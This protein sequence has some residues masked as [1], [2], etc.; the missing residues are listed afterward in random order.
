MNIYLRLRSDRDILENHGLGTGGR[1]QRFVDSEALRRCDRYTPKRTGELIRS[2][3]RGTVIGSG[4]I[5]YTAPYAREQYN[6]NTGRGASGTASG[7]LRGRLWFV[8]MKQAHRRTILEGAARI[9]GCRY[10][11]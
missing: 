10:H 5:I 7:G 11:D 8:R 3:L 9:A 4:R 1:V 6:F 2:G